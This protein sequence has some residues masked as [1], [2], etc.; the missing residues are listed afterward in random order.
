MAPGSE[1]RS[2]ALHAVK[3]LQDLAICLEARIYFY[4]D[5]AFYT[6]K[7]GKGIMS[8]GA[9]CLVFIVVVACGILVIIV[10]SI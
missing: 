9:T 8:E 6:P 1:R 7:Q 5:A 10:V 2:V 3:T 4:H